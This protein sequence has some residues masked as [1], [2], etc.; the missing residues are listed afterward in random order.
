MKLISGCKSYSNKI[1]FENLN[2]EFPH[3]GL[4]LITGESGRGKSTLL[5]VFFGVDRLDSGELIYDGRSMGYAIQKNGLFNWTTVNKNLTYSSIFTKNEIEHKDKIASVFGIEDLLEE[6]IGNLSGGEAQRVNTYKEIIKNR[7]IILFDEPT[8]ALDMKTALKVSNV[9]YEL[10]KSKLIIVAT[11]EIKHFINMDYTEIS[12]DNINNNIIESSIQ[13]IQNEEKVFGNKISIIKFLLSAIKGKLITFSLLFTLITTLILFLVSFLREPDLT[14]MKL[15]YYK[16]NNITNVLYSKASMSNHGFIYAANNILRSD[17]E[18][19]LS[20]IDGIKCYKNAGRFDFRSIEDY[21]ITNPNWIGISDNCFFDVIYGDENISPNGISISNSFAKSIL[22]DYNS[23]LGYNY[24][25]VSELISTKI[26]MNRQEYTIESIFKDNN[27]VI[28][29]EMVALMNKS[30]YDILN[31]GYSVISMI[32]GK[33]YTLVVNDNIDN[34]LLGEINLNDNEIIINQKLALELFDSLDRAIGKTITFKTLFCGFD[35]EEQKKYGY[36]NYAKAKTEEYVIKGISGDHILTP[37]ELKKTGYYISC[38]KNKHIELFDYALNF[39]ED[40]A[41]LVRDIDRNKIDT[42]YNMGLSEYV[43][44]RNDY[45]N[46]A[47]VYNMDY[48]SYACTKLIRGIELGVLLILDIIVLLVYYVSTKHIRKDILLSLKLE[49]FKNKK[50]LFII[51]FDLLIFVIATLISSL[52][53]SIWYISDK[54]LYNYVML[55][56]IIKI[57]SYSILYVFFFS[58]AILF[59]IFLMYVQ[60]Y[61]MSKK[62]TI[63]YLREKK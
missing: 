42:L 4:V 61:K 59:M 9:L 40:S 55:G 18:E 7:D 13:K 32:D 21:S 53:G 41:V 24:K 51:S 35:Y 48:C 43:I 2:I 52:I 12:L 60:I 54:V 30:T 63:L 38:L 27:S 14:G 57:N 15:D 8:S 49:K 26:M 28:S 46:M 17:A 34:L 56:A 50:T 3:N 58:I 39:N 45:T 11:H 5:N 23:Y 16:E 6:K 62:D 36:I 22:Y 33:N 44:N 1:I 20:K 25:N 37:E 29:D 10:S 19:V 47:Y 31:G